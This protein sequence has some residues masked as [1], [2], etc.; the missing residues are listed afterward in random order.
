MLIP[1]FLAFIG[2]ILNFIKSEKKTVVIQ[3]NVFYAIIKK[4]L[5]L[6]NKKIKKS[7]NNLKINIY[8]VKTIF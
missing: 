5:L 2:F 3:L 4:K 7:P 1:V 6:A 8:K